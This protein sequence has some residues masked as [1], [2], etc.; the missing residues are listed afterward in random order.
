M[1]HVLRTFPAIFA[2]S[3]FGSGPAWAAQRL[4]TP[5]PLPEAGALYET[6]QAIS[7]R[8]TLAGQHNYPATKARNSEFAAKYTG[9]M[10]AVWTSDF[11]FAAAGDTDSYL[12][13]P[14]IVAEAV[15]QHRQGALVS[16]CWHAVPP[17]ASEPVTFQP[18][19]GA[20]PA[21]LQS[22]QGRLT[23]EQFRD[24]LTPGT[25]LHAKWQEQVDAIAVFLKQLQDARV[26]VLWRPYHEMNG[27]WFW[28]GGRTEG[29]HTTAAL[30]RQIFDRLV[31]HHGLKNL[32]WVWSVDRVTRP[33]MEHDRYFPGLEFVDVLA[34]DV[35]RN[36]FAQSYYDSLVAL[37]GGKPL[38]LA[39][40]GNPPGADVLARQ[41]RWVYYV[42]WAGMVRN[43]TRKQY[44]EL[45]RDPRVLNLADHAYAGAMAGYR[46]A[47][48][49]PPIA[50]PVPPAD[51]SGTWVLNEELSR[52]GPF[53]PGFTPVR[54]SVT[55]RDGRLTVQSTLL[56]EYADD[57]VSEQSYSLDGRETKHVF[58]NLP[59]M[60]K[61]RI[62]ADRSAIILEST[63]DV[64][65]GPP[66]TKWQTEERWT[67]EESGQKLVIHN[68]SPAFGESPPGRVEQTFVYERR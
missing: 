43:T 63:S 17:T 15:R 61:A 39:E 22:V 44:A 67:L 64:P 35:Y 36:D 6:L 48:G 14:E 1:T 11:G 66:G 54:L 52:F 16:L 29:P 2:L 45:F 8:Y 46:R 28:W 26:P 55:Q 57:E 30:Y 38:V 4:V 47:C 32:I 51:F 7:G 68:V 20:D 59:R 31:R 23:D 65:F 58:R 27:N 3:L 19:P 56:S 33:G 53:G 37:S 60:T 18:K 12:A 13:R 9:K 41:S 62:S 49:L 5:D 40:V 25:E 21:R 34:L 24:V 10:P 50:I 42:T